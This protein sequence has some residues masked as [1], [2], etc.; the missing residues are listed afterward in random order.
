MSFFRNLRNVNRPFPNH[1]SFV[2]ANT[3]VVNNA[4]SG[5][6]NVFQTPSSQSLQNNTVLGGYQT[7]AGFVSTPQMNSFMRNNDVPR[8]RQ[9]FPNANTNQLDSLSTLR[10]M[11]NVPDA[12]L[13][14]NNLRRQSVKTN[15]P[16]TN[17]RTAEGVTNVL[18][19]QPRLSRYLETAKQ[20]GYVGLVGVGVV[21][22]ARTATVIGDIVEA[23]R[24][25]G[26]SYYHIGLNGGEQVESCLLRYR[27]CVLDVNNL[28]DVDVCPSD[29]LID[30]LNAL[31]SVCHG[32][33]AEVE[34]TVCRRSDPNAD[35]LS[36]QYVDISPLATGHTISC[37]EPYDFGDLIG[38][39]G[40]DGLLGEEG[41]LNKSSDKS[42]T[43]FQKLLP[44]IVVLGIVLL[45][46][47][48]G[49]I[50][51]KR[52]LMQPPPPPAN[53]NR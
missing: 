2:T 18:N 13:H 49:Y 9:V 10:R 20:A 47:F 17:T 8:L 5:F 50:V 46:I 34:R 28:N 3:S 4:P 26:G 29:P 42:S 19:Q 15:F 32:Y 35:P 53:Y 37:I 38:D 51:I 48:I 14:A 16:S 33:N 31:Q 52:M 22:V 43:S 27:T 23:L 45:I 24:R 1:A 41:L 25:T 7:P 12:R 39:L 30:N 21:L 6:N 36:L 11:D 44:I 40:L